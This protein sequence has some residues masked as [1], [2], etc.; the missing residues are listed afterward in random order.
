[1]HLRPQRP[2]PPQGETG[3]PMRTLGPTPP[4]SVWE[5]HRGGNEVS[6]CA[7]T[8]DSS[9]WQGAR[10]WP[11]SIEANDAFELVG[12]YM[13]GDL[14]GRP[15]FACALGLPGLGPA[16]HPLGKRSLPILSF[17]FNVSGQELTYGTTLHDKYITALY[18]NTILQYYQI[19]TAQY[20]W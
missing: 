10:T 3:P 9:V 14:I 13:Y 7:S 19:S 8:F 20:Y 15:T 11:T 18:N 17:F 1:M 4:I 16:C 5:H 6:A 2:P 12:A